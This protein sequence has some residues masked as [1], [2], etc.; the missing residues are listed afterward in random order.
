MEADVVGLKCAFEWIGKSRLMECFE[1]LAQRN[2]GFRKSHDFV[3]LDVMRPIDPR[4]IVVLTESVIITALS[5][6]NFIA[7]E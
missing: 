2:H 3:G 6:P 4:N 1:S 7:T 5:A